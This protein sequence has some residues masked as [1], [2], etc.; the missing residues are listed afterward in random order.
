MPISSKFWNKKGCL[1]SP[2][3]V[4]TGLE[5]LATLL[6]Q[7]K[8]MKTIQVGNEETRVPFIADNMLVYIDILKESM[9]NTLS[10][11]HGCTDRQVRAVFL[12]ACTGAEGAA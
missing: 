9:K 5:V 1:L 4:N 8:K 12:G 3:L 11:F 6:R 2:L 7:R 10:Y